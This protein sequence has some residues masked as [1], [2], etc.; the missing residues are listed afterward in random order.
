MKIVG[1]GGGAAHIALTTRSNGSCDWGF[2]NA[3]N[4]TNVALTRAKR[5]VVLMGDRQ[6]FEVATESA[7]RALAEY[8]VAADLD[9]TSLH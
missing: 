9:E 3:P 5:F 7:V 2:L 4:R 8:S 1:A 6:L